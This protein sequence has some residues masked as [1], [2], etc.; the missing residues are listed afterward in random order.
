ME[1]GLFAGGWRR[2]ARCVRSES[3]PDFVTGRE[4]SMPDIKDDQSCQKWRVAPITHC[5][6][7]RTRG[8]EGEL[9]EASYASRAG[10]WGRQWH[11]QYDPALSRYLSNPLHDCVANTS[12][13]VQPER[14]CFI[15]SYGKPNILSDVDGSPYAISFPSAPAATS[16]IN[17]RQAP[18]SH[19]DRSISVRLGIEIP[20][21]VL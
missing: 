4:F 10:K 2:G 7:M 16:S 1:V 11:R 5:A 12:S 14:A 13:N 9:V 8:G 18:F 3:M 20:N 21:D 17:S 19:L 6:T 15:Q